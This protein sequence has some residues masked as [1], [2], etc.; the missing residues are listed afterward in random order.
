MFTGLI[1]T[2]GTVENLQTTQEGAYI[3]IKAHWKNNDLKKGDS[4]SINGACQTITNL[5]EQASIFE[6]YSSF[7]TLELTNLGLLQIGEIVNLERALLPTTRMGGH[8]VQGHVDNMG[9]VCSRNKRDSGKVEVFEIEVPHSLTPY[10]IER[11]SIAIDGISLT[12]VAIQGNIVQLVL[13]PETI[14]KTNAKIW[15]PFKKVNIEIDILSRYI[16]K[17]LQTLKNI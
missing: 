15:E 16:E 9:V 17:Q 12:V 14:E 8:I 3:L 11:G 7:K 5:L 10:I 4:I 6:V 1:E 13:I 2:L